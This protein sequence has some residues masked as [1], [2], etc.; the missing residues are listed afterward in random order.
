[1][2]ADKFYDGKIDLSEEDIFDL[3]P[4]GPSKFECMNVLLF[5]A[6][7]SFRRPVFWRKEQTFIVYRL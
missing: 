7:F 1:M 4:Q 2:E 6:L 5:L 3:V